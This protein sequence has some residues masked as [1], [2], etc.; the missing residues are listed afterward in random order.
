MTARET[1]TAVTVKGVDLWR[2]HEG[3]KVRWTRRYPGQTEPHA[4]AIWYH[5]ARDAGSQGDI[6]GTGAGL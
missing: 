1:V 5:R 2:A 3:R 6:A 4:F